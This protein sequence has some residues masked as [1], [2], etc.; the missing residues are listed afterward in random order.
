[1]KKFALILIASILALSLV[2]CA[3]GETDNGEGGN[4][5]DYM[6]S[7]HQQKIYA[8]DGKTILGTLSFE[9]GIGDTAIISDYV[10]VHTAHIVTIPANVGPAEAER[11][12]TAIGKEAFYYCTSIKTVVIPEGVTYIGDYAFAGCTGLESIIIPAS[13]TSIGK[14]AFNGCSSLAEIKFADGSQLLSIGDY[15]F[16]DCITLGLKKGADDTTEVVS[17]E[18][19]EGLL[20]IGKEAFRD[21]VA[22]TSFKTPASLKSI[23]DMAFYNCEGFN[24]ENAK[25]DLSAS[26]NITIT[27]E[28]KIDEVTG[29]ELKDEV[30]G[31]T[32]EDE[33]IAIGEFVFGN[34]DVNNIGVPN[35][36]TTGVAKYVAALKEP[37]DVVIPDEEESSEESSEESTE[38]FIG[39]IEG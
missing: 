15:A 27:Y 36:P 39:D 25:L 21:C 9:D 31:E 23:G 37:G 6:Q 14:G 33:I 29:E 5:E 1:M 34:I 10:G 18:L 4:V 3:N 13:V 32:I 12:V 38:E 11:K 35:D 2:A 30:T 24:Q 26:V 16:N 28:P 19:P 8:N 20:T 17:I 7:S 22:M